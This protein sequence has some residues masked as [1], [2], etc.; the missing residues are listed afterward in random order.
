MEMEG[1]PWLHFYSS[2]GQSLP[3]SSEALDGVPSLVAQLAHSVLRLLQ[4]EASPASSAALEDE[5]LMDLVVAAGGKP[6][7]IAT[8]GSPSPSPTPSPRR[9]QRTSSSSESGQARGANG[10]FSEEEES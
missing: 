7:P 6:L 5:S 2:P 3:E 1:R 8:S 4:E 10:R 9:P